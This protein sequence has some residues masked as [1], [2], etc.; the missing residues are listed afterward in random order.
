MLMSKQLTVAFAW[1]HFAQ[2]MNSAGF[3]PN[4]HFEVLGHVLISLV[5]TLPNERR[6][7]KMPERVPNGE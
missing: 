3:E 2:N 6:K 7:L 4:I 1:C 5:K